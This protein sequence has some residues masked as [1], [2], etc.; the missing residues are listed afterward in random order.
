MDC[1]SKVHYGMKSSDMNLDVL[2]TASLLTATSVYT[3]LYP[4]YYS[5]CVCPVPNCLYTYCMQYYGLIP[6]L[7]CLLQPKKKTNKTQNSDTP[8]F[9]SFPIS[10]LLLWT[11]LPNT[12]SSVYVLY[13]YSY[14]RLSHKPSWAGCISCRWHLKLYWL[15]DW[16]WWPRCSIDWAMHCAKWSI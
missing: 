8:P 13:S 4:Y 12:V 7:L 5:V 9:P 1:W 16:S 11:D 15:I 3:Q 2:K 6:R 14:V 10:Y